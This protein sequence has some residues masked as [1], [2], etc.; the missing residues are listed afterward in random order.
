M[1]RCL[2]Q[3]SPPACALPPLIRSYVGLLRE[4]GLEGLAAVP[5]PATWQ[6]RIVTETPQR[7]ARADNSTIIDRE[8]AASEWGSECTSP[9]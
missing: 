6:Q 7:C 2:S 1:H 8:S 4:E 5:P 9:A 3:S